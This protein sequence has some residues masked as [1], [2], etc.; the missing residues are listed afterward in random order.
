MTRETTKQFLGRSTDAVV[1]VAAILT[2]AA[3]FIHGFLARP[4]E[5]VSD[6]LGLTAVH[7]LAQRILALLL[8]VAAWNLRRR[9]RAAWI[10]AVVLLSASIVVN[11]MAF[12]RLFGGLVA[13]LKAYALIGLIVARDRYQRPSERTTVRRAAQ[14]AAIIL[15]IVVLNLIIGQVVL[16]RRDGVGAFA[17][18]PMLTWLSNALTGATDP[19]PRY[20]WFVFILFWGSAAGCLLLILHA[21][22]IGRLMTNEERQRARDL[23]LRYGQNPHSYLTLE[24]DKRLFFGH[25][26]EAVVAYGVVGDTVVV[27]GDPICAPDNFVVALAEFRSFCETVASG[28]IFLGVTQRFLPKYREFGYQITKC[29]EEA[30][31]DL[32]TY[33]MAGSAAAKARG[34]V[35]RA[36]RA[37]ITV[38]EYQPAAKR[39]HATEAAIARVS[40]EWLRGKKSGALGFT[41]SGNDLDEPMDRRYFVALDDTGTVCGYNVFL[42]YDAGAGWLVDITR[43]C[44]GAVPGVTE[45]L[46]AE[47]FNVFKQ[48]GATSAS[49]GLA[50]LT[51]VVDQDGNGS[52]DEKLLNQIY[53][54]FNRLYGFKDL[55]TAKKKYGPTGWRPLYFAYTGKHLTPQLLYATIAVQAPRGLGAFARSL[56]SSQREPIDAEARQ[57]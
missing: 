13:L 30:R 27:L 42:P 8:I 15:G 22:T 31:F 43:R 3:S 51:N 25:A 40:R 46:V 55:Q 17:L 18:G 37:G 49:M 4:A 9:M 26:V 34:K 7:H 5:V 44:P 10:L 20:A 39:E 14:L 41:V 45:L 38:R 24:H 29:G 50:P 23:V 36:R 57:D 48:E 16:H 12:P 28:C 52:A 19:L 6:V 2:F 32:A 33:A 47:G 11:L 1:F 35:S 53:Q 54:R 21:A 56:V